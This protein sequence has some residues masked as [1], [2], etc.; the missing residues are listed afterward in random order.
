MVS[1]TRLSSA[2]APSFNF[3]KAASSGPIGF[4]DEVVGNH[5]ADR[6]PRPDGDCRLDAERP[7]YHLLASLIYALPHP[8]LDRFGERTVAVAAH[9]G[10]RSDAQ[11]GRQD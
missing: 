2:I 1:F 9:T 10:L 4:E 3:A 8:L 6:K 11:N 5:H 7:A